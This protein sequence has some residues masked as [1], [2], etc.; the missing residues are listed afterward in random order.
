M[1]SLSLS[2]H[3][4]TLHAHASKGRASK[5]RGKSRKR[6]QG[7]PGVQ[8]PSPAAGKGRKPERKRPGNPQPAKSLSTWQRFKARALGGGLLAM[9]MRGFMTVAALT[10][11]A[12]AM[13]FFKDAAVA[14]RFGVSDALDAFMLAFGVHSFAVSLLGGIIPEAFLPVYAQVKHERGAR[15]AER[16]GVQT[17]LGHLVILGGL[18]GLIALAGPSVVSFLGHGF[19]AE[20]Q[21]LALR[22]LLDLLPFLFCYGLSLHLGMWLRGNKLFAVAAA[23]PILT[24]ACI[25]AAVVWMAQDA[26]VEVLVWSTNLGSALH[27][28][29]LLVVVARR[30]PMTRRWLWTCVRLLE[31]GNRQVLANAWPFLLAGL[32]LGGAPMVDQAMAARL[33]SGSVAVLSYSDKVCAILLAL[34]AGAAS[35]ALFPFFADLVAKR[36]W[37]G[38]R[39]K[40]MQI[41]G[42]ILAVAVPAVALLC[43]QAP[44]IV[45]LLFE[46]GNFDAHDTER[47]AHVLRFA[48]LQIPF[49]IASV[50]MSRVVVSLQASWFILMAA[51]FSLVANIVFN[52]ILM[53]YFGVAGIALSTAIVYLLSCVMLTVYLIKAMGRLMKQETREVAAA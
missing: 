38:L 3:A 40:L 23:S 41:I 31:P 17:A 53:R 33:E 43:W 49:Y 45:S 27:L 35:E 11:L 42:G 47:V 24:P 8:A 4:A 21:A 52:A 1:S 22:T 9:M 26:S 29:V 19:P 39:L 50:L 37:H 15:R 10:L 16:M 51:A 6:R 5:P 44:L 46:R 7:K 13:S 14:H 30:L 12:K 32:V 25:L 28:L 48:A 34:T 18:G 36:D 2:P 20:K